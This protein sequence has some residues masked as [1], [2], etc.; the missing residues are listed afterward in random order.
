[1]HSTSRSDHRYVSHT[2]SLVII[3]TMAVGE[4]CGSYTCVVSANRKKSNGDV[5]DTVCLTRQLFDEAV[6]KIASSHGMKTQYDNDTNFLKHP[7]KGCWF[8]VLEARDVNLY[9]SKRE[10]FIRLGSTRQEGPK[11]GSKQSIGDILVSF[12]DC[13]RHRRVDC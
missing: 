2:V 8:G 5:G 13:T 11:W 12:W 4:S 3:G 1:M 10:D 6:G 7:G 9:R